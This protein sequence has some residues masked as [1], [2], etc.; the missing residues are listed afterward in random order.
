[1]LGKFVSMTATL[2]LALVA[3]PAAAERQDGT[4]IC[5]Y[6]AQKQYGENSMTTQ[7]KLMSSIVAFAYAGGDKMKGADGNATGIFRSG[8]IG[9]DVV[10][11]RG[12]FDGSMKTSN[13]NDEPAAVN[14]LDGGGVE[15]LQAYINGTTD[16]AEIKKDTNQYT[17]FTHW[18]VAFGRIYGCTKVEDFVDKK[19]RTFMPAYVHKYM[20]LDKP[21]IA[22]F[23]RQLILASKYYGFSE[24]DADTL[25]T[26]M[27]GRYNI[28]CAPAE[29]N[30]LSSICF[31][32]SCPLA[33]PKS[34]CDAYNTIKPYGVDDN[35]NTTQTP[36]TQPAAA[37]GSKSGLGGG[38]IAGIAVGS[39]AG[40]GL[41]I[42]ALWFFFKKKAEKKKAV[43][44]PESIAVSHATSGYHNPSMYSP[45]MTQSGR[46]DMTGQ[47]DVNLPGHY[48]PSR[49]SQFTYFSNGHESYMPANSPPP[50]G[51]V[52]MP[53]QELHATEMASPPTSPTAG[54]GV[55]SHMKL[56]H[57]P[58]VREIVE[59]ES[60]SPQPPQN[61]IWGQMTPNLETGAPKPEAKPEPKPDSH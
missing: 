8:M 33:F 13:F 5:D 10:V 42:G 46:Y 50:Q 61:N 34:D 44:R 60:P 48:D 12:Y 59:M 25:E 35:Y 47:Y 3:Q 45:T 15:P 28:K 57:K 23:I 32:K 54:H 1:M 7:L 21:K 51:W 20:D 18:Y 41:V 38:A 39:L 36:A 24:A 52:E 14:W 26:L 9:S 27:N 49:Q 40:I 58:D 22:Y 53:P 31:A 2:L 56:E 6:Y 43:N 11:L 16:M 19:Y 17:L 37:G 30:M 29:K 55:D 4:S